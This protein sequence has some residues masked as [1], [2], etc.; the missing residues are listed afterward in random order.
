MHKDASSTAHFGWIKWMDKQQKCVVFWIMLTILLITYRIFK[1][2]DW[3]S[4]QEFRIGL[5][6]NLINFSVELW[7]WPGSA[8]YPYNSF[9]FRN[10]NFVMN[11]FIFVKT[12]ESTA[13]R[14]FCAIFTTSTFFLRC[15]SFCEVD[16]TNKDDLFIAFWTICKLCRLFDAFH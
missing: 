10:V 14:L 2:M 7:S 12:I 16:I 1:R 15:I 11:I 8:Q 6:T 9:W 13:W 4:R 5:K 3:T